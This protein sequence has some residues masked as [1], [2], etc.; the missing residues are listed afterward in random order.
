MISGKAFRHYQFTEFTG[1]TWY[2]PFHHSLIV[3]C[4]N[5]LVY[6]FD[7]SLNNLTQL[8][9]LISGPQERRHTKQW[10]NSLINISAL[11]FRQFCSFSESRLREKRQKRGDSVF[12]FE[13]SP[14]DSQAQSERLCHAGRNWCI[15]SC[16]SV[17]FVISEMI[18]ISN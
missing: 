14:S 18:A 8:K 13:R 3:D 5:Q 10:T 16:W 12:Q 2:L 17:V 15:S 9:C 1:F 7:M 6:V 4:K 11:I